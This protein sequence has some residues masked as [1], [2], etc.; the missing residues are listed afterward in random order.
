MC[1]HACRFIL[2]AV[3]PAFFPVT[4]SG[5]ISVDLQNNSP[6]EKLLSASHPFLCL[7]FCSFALSVSSPDTDP[8]ELL[9]SPSPL[10]VFCFRSLTLSVSFY[11]SLSVKIP[12]G[13]AV[14][15][16]HNCTQTVRARTDVD[17]NARA[18]PASLLSTGVFTETR[19][20]S[21]RFS[22]TPTSPL[23]TH[24]NSTKCSIFCHCVV[25]YERCFSQQADSPVWNASFHKSILNSHFSAS[26]PSPPL[27]S[28]FLSGA[29]LP[30]RLLTH[31]QY[32]ECVYD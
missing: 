26:P 2:S 10:F 19:D 28:S 17:V 30:L 5:Q 16:K 20:R 24:T 8:P 23:H 15:H 9:Y 27:I 12:C 25:I 1:V 22:C 13:R 6:E 31:A 14:S 7:P 3:D 29:G 32:S 11:I 18:S 4:G 21:E